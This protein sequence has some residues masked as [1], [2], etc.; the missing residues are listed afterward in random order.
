M[1]TNSSSRILLTS[2]GGTRRFEVCDIGK[3]G[4]VVV[5]AVIEGVGVGVVARDALNV[6]NHAGIDDSAGVMP[7]PV[8]LAAVIMHCSL[9][10][11]LGKACLHCLT[12]RHAP[13]MLMCLSAHYSYGMHARTCP[14][15][16]VVASL[17]ITYL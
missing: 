2:F 1:S 9:Y 14:F 10:Y 6:V 11:N 17:P 3:R 13:V 5:A 7:V 8:I 16:F 12:G 15:I 4:G